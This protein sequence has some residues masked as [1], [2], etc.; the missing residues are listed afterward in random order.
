MIKHN[1]KPL[2]KT[3]FRHCQD[4][5]LIILRNSITEFCV[6]LGC[7]FREHPKYKAWLKNPKAGVPAL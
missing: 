7:E 6:K 4:C 2:F 5:G 1:V 3:G